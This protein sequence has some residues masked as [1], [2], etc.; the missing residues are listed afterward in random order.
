MENNLSK[1]KKVT[2]LKHLP[3]LIYYG[4]YGFLYLGVLIGIYLVCEY[5]ANKSTMHLSDLG[6]VFGGTVGAIWSLSGVLFF[7]YN[8]QQQKETLFLQK[9]ELR[10]QRQELKN[11]VGE[12]Q[13]ANTTAS[14]QQKAIAEQTLNSLFYT[15]LENNKRV[16]RDIELVK[17]DKLKD[18]LI[19][20]TEQYKIHLQSK[21]FFTCETTQNC[22]T[23]YIF[24]K[25][26][27]MMNDFKNF[28]ENVVD[29][30][31]FVE[32]NI[33]KK[34]FYHKMFFNQLSYSEKFLIGF[35]LNYKLFK[36]E[37][38]KSS[39]EY[40][41]I[42]KSSPTFY[43]PELEDYIPALDIGIYQANEVLLTGL[44]IYKGQS[45]TK[46]IQFDILQN[47][48]KKELILKHIQAEFSFPLLSSNIILN[49]YGN[50]ET[51]IDY[52]KQIPLNEIFGEINLNPNQT[53]KICLTFTFNYLS[54]NYKVRHYV[55][56]RFPSE[57]QKVI[58]AVFGN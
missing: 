43:S 9:E 28:I 41:K 22:P 39:F 29:I 2:S 18:E 32:E 15:L 13:Q 12:M 36:T 30:I 52:K 57:P 37:N 53:Y 51:K 58:G 7:I 16:V 31:G 55:E 17:L 23:Y 35:V 38:V 25:Y 1:T 21:E 48:L 5:N 54:A 44:I 56:A 3:N 47:L 24:H 46:K 40:S 19:L 33:E 34:E 10:L 6:T 14:S 27:D 45:D 42:F 4:A 20:Y 49:K 11:Q 8:L 50:Y 26:N